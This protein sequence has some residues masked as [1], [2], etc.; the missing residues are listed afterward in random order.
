MYR[1]LECSKGN[2]ERK[3]TEIKYPT[4]A[5]EESKPE[6]VVKDTQ[7]STTSQI[8]FEI[9]YHLTPY[10]GGQKVTEFKN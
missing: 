3:E 10:E 9:V 6:T 2:A 4:P 7:S 1:I 8:L 5:K